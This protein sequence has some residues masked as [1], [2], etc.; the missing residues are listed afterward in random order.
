MFLVLPAEVPTKSAKKKR[1]RRQSENV[2]PNAPAQPPKSGVKT[3]KRVLSA[4]KTSNKP[5]T[6]RRPL[7]ENV[8]QLA[9]GKHIDISRQLGSSLSL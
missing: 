7:S 9:P 5:Y 2:D 8:N 1:T 3:D 4:V 6:E